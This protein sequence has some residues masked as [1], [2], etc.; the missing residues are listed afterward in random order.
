MKGSSRQ[1]Q[2]WVIKLMHLIIVEQLDI[3]SIIKKLPSWETEAMYRILRHRQPIFMKPVDQFGINTVFYKA[4]NVIALQTKGSM[5][6]ALF[7][8]DW[9]H[10]IFRLLHLVVIDII[11]FDFN[12]CE[13]VLL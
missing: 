9:A 10:L 6:T 8:R 4:R 2:R 5:N 7:V 12:Y 11:T 3:L 13:Y 1:K